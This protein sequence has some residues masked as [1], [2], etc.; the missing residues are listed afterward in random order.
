MAYPIRFAD[1]EAIR[2][3][4]QRVEALGYDSVLV[5]DHY[6][7]MP[8]VREAFDEPPRF[9]EPL[10]TLT[11]V[12]AHTSRIKMMTGVVVMPLREPVLL[13]KQVA[14]LDQISGGRFILGLGVGAYRPEYTSVKPRQASVP[15]GAL[16][17]EGMEA[18]I[19]LFSDRRASYEGKYTAFK[20]V[21]M[22]PKPLQDPFPLISCGNAPGTIT[23]AATL[24]AGWMPAGLPDDRIAAGVADMRRQAIE[25]GRDPDQLMVASQTVLCVDDNLEA[26][27]ARFRSS[28]VYEHLVSL[29]QS[30]L[31]D[32]DIDAYMGQNLIG[33]PE[34]IIDRIH[35][36]AEI[37]V[38][39]LAGLI[40]V[41][42]TEAEFVDQV[43]RFA[44]EVL[45]AFRPAN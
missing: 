19:R 31:K 20:D 33:S 14:C 9:Y 3:L 22:Y 18:L 44:A 17:A 24:C 25:A 28:Q 10:V 27:A 11:Y 41:A 1:H 12:A 39:H 13:A 30:T 45:P 15:R 16:V 38:N 4:A 23:R 36:L 29:R 40:V 21:E 34:R 43:E 5:N 26:A 37:G 32:V 42:N 35:K 7:T 6:S 8:Y 2:R